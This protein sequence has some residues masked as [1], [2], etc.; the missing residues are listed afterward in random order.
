MIM[1][2]K[3]SEQDSLQLINEMIAQARDN[4]RKGSGDFMVIAGYVIVVAAI[5]DFVLFQVLDKPH[6]AHW[7]WS[8]MLPYFIFFHDKRKNERQIADRLHIR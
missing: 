4:V 8:L 6:M 2:K 3:F 7:V 1:E 5:A